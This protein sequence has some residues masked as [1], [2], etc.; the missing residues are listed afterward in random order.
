MGVQAQVPLIPWLTILP[1]RPADLVTAAPALLPWLWHGYLAQGR[2]T[3]FVS[4][5]KSGTHAAV[6]CM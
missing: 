1:L 6:S 2:V 4:Q 3:A 5:S